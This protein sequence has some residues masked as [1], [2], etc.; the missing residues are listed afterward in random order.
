MSMYTKYS[1][2]QH[3]KSINALTP[4]MMSKQMGIQEK[5][6]LLSIWAYASLVYFK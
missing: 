4:E 6:Q 5:Q 1:R 2:L 3:I